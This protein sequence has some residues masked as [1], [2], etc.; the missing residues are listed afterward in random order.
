MPDLTDRSTPRLR[1]LRAALPSSLGLGVQPLVLA[2][3]AALTLVLA[4]LPS[5]LAAQEAAVEAPA[6]P[7]AESD[8]RERI[9]A[10]YEVEPTEEGLV[11]RPREEYRGIRRLEIEGAELSINGATVSSDDARGWLGE[12]A[13][14][15]LRLAALPEDERAR[16]FDQDVAADTVAEDTVEDLAED[17]AEVLEAP[18]APEPPE[19]PEPPRAPRVRRGSQT[20]VGSTVRIAADEVAEDV[21]AFGGSVVVR[22]LVEGDVTAFGGD[23][24]VDGEVTRDVTS[25]GGQVRLG[26]D[27]EVGGDVTSVGGHVTRAPG[28]VVRG[29]IEEVD[30][31][32]SRGWYGPFW[33]WD[34]WD[35]WERPRWS[36]WDWIWGLAWP[37]VE[38]LF[39][40]LLMMLVVAIGR[41]TVEGIGT[42]AG[43]EPVKSGLVGLLVAILTV[44]VFIIVS[45]LL[46]VSIIGIPILIVLVL[47]FVFVGVPGL[48]VMALVGYTG[49]SWRLG[50]WTERRF[51]WQLESPFVAVLV[52]LLFLHG[53]EVV[54]QALDAGPL[55][56]FA[57]MFL[58]MAAVAQLVAG[59]IGFGATF[60]LLYERRARRRTAL[61]PPPP[62]GTPPPAAP[63]ELPPEVP[64]TP[65]PPAEEPGEPR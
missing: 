18:E 22:G 36:T 8:L 19:P 10:A 63:P 6:D 26:E 48:L 38:I 55:K 21:V 24:D 39:L 40:A 51:G 29:S 53:L 12:R 47:L 65:P 54:G 41:Q 62:P 46:A 35:G 60:L 25:I 9:E 43:A 31:G 30:E 33:G 44:P 50:R 57:V 59:C 52:G 49:V 15:V 20:V 14:L 1:R 61:A 34:W 64:D 5:P 11:L 27:A 23:V 32:W 17:E 28:A 16:L 58:V 3:I 4:P 2:L 56:P 37:L 13:D 42:R 45:V 7:A